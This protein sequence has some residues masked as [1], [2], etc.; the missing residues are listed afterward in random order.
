MA[1]HSGRTFR[2]LLRALVLASEGRNVR[3]LVSTQILE[4]HLWR[5][6]VTMCDVYLTPA[7]LHADYTLHKITFPNGGAVTF[8]TAQRNT[9]GQEWVTIDEDELYDH[10]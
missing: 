8:M 3:F 1:R 9:R 6:A 4:K 2:Q 10:R 7:T 5:K